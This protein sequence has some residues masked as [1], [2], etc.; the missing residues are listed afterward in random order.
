MDNNYHAYGD[1]RKEYDSIQRSGDSRRRYGKS[2]NSDLIN[3]F[4]LLKCEPTFRRWIQIINSSDGSRK[5]FK[6]IIG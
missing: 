4:Q 2:M 6:N 5:I 1:C 3:T